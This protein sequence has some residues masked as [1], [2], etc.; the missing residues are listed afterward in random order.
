MCTTEHWRRT[1]SGTVVPC[2]GFP[3]RAARG[4]VFLLTFTFTPHELA[5]RHGIGKGVKA[6]ALVAINMIIACP[7]GAG[8]LHKT[9]SPV[10][11][12][13]G[14]CVTAGS[15]ASSPGRTL[16]AHRKGRVDGNGNAAMVTVRT[17]YGF[18]I[19]VHPAYAGKFLKFF[20]LLK[21]RGYK[22]QHYQVLAASRHACR[23]LQS[24]HWCGLRHPD[25]LESRARFC[26]PHQRH[27]QTSRPV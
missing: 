5:R 26:V 8:Q 4:Q 3:E 2:A 16:R 11:D 22:V 27:H 13:N 7:A 18:N 14:R 19:T 1:L 15:T 12:N 21:D 25:R 20:V 17:T 9:T 10:C 23:R 24:L 6:L